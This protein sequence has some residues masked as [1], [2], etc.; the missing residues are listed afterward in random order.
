MGD[1]HGREDVPW[2]TSTGGRD[3]V[4]RKWLRLVLSFFSDEDRGSSGYRESGRQY[5]IPK[6]IRYWLCNR[7][8]EIRYDL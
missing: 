8:D 7:E 6:K 3:D 1:D 4:K 2:E 5:S